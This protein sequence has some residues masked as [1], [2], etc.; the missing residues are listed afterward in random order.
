M[1]V[2]ARI[3]ALH[4]SPSH[5]CRYHL[6]AVD[7]YH[8]WKSGTNFSLG[9]DDGSGV[10][11]AVAASQYCG[12]RPEAVEPPSEVARLAATRLRLVNVH[13]QGGQKTH[14]PYDVCRVLLRTGTK[15]IVNAHLRAKVRL[16]PPFMLGAS[17][18]PLLNYARQCAEEIQRHVAA[19]AVATAGNNA[20]AGTELQALPCQVHEERTPGIKICF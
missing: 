14:L 16:C 9:L 18:T 10:P 4:V 7:H 5:P 17:L 19:A 13:Y 15:A 8:G 12:G 20:T 11:S 1:C 6:L 3:P 2:C